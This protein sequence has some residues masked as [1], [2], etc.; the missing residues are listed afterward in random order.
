[1]NQNNCLFL[2]TCIGIKRMEGGREGNNLRQYL[3]EK[4]LVMSTHV[5]MEFNKTVI[6]DG[7]HLYS[8]LKEDKN[9]TVTD[10]YWRIKK[11]SESGDSSLAS[12]ARRLDLL[13]RQLGYPYQEEKNRF[14]TRLEN[15]MTRILRKQFLFNLILIESQ[16]K[17]TIA[18][19]KV[20]Y[21]KDTD[22]L[23]INMDCNEKKCNITDFIAKNK[24]MIQNLR[25]NC[26]ASNPDFSNLSKVFA[27]FVSCLDTTG[28]GPINDVVIAL[29]CKHHGES[30]LFS[31]DTQHI[32]C[33]CNELNLGLIIMDKGKII[34]NRSFLLV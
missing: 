3:N 22:L 15:L 27:D 11:M 21:S 33:I 13:I 24:S 31:S 30:K 16:S 20:H 14:L 34:G 32:P 1:M 25:K 5:L 7:V 28:I 17:C 12:K 10:I 8:M 26:R 23:K 9:S 29:D 18:N 2:D 4:Q 19:N 6:S